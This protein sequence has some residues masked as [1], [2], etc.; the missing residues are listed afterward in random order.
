VRQAAKRDSSGDLDFAHS[1]F[2]MMTSSSA[3]SPTMKA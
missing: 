3:C 1:R 2:R